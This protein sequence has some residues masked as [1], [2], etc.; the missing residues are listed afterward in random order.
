MPIDVCL[1]LPLIDRVKELNNIFAR[2]NLQELHNS[3]VLVVDNIFGYSCGTEGWALHAVN[4]ADEPHLFG[5]IREFLSPN[6]RFLEVLS[7]RLTLEFPSVYHDFPLWLLSTDSQNSV[8]SGGCKQPRTHLSL[9]AFT[10]YMFA[11]MCYASYPKWKQELALCDFENSLYRTLFDDYL[12]FYLYTDPTTV[13]V[14]ASKFHILRAGLQTPGYQKN[15]SNEFVGEYMNGSTDTCFPD[16]RLFWQTEAVLQAVCEFLLSWRATDYFNGISDLPKNTSVIPSPPLNHTEFSTKPTV[17][18]LFLVRCFLKYFYFALFN[19]TNSN[20]FQILQ[21]QIIW[22]KFL[23]YRK[24]LY[25]NQ[26][27]IVSP[28]SSIPHHNIMNR[29]SRFIVYC[30]QHWPFDLSFEVVLET[31]LSSIQPWRYSGFPQLHTGTR[32]SSIPW[33]APLNL[34]IDNENYS[35]WL[36]F[37]ARHYSL[38][39]GLLLLFME[40]VTKIDLRVS[41]NAHMVYRVTKVFSQDG[42]KM[43]LL[44]TEKI[45][46]EQ[47]QDATLSN[48]IVSE[49]QRE[50]SGLW[51][52]VIIS[53]VERVLNCMMIT[54]VNLQSE[55]IKKMDKFL[56]DSNGWFDKFTKWLCSFLIFDMDNSDESVNKCI[57]YLTEGIHSLREFFAI[58]ETFE[59]VHDISLK[60]PPNGRIQWDDLSAS[61][62]LTRPHLKS[63]PT[64]SKSP[65]VEHPYKDN[66]SPSDFS[67]SSWNID[68]CSMPKTFVNSHDSSRYYTKLT[69]LD[70]FQI[71]MGVKRPYVC[72]QLINREYASTMNASYENRYILTVCKY[73]ENKFTEMMKQHFI[74]WCSLSGIRGRFARQLLLPSS[75]PKQHESQSFLITNNPRLSFRF[76]A[77]YY[78]LLRIIFLYIFS[79]FLSG[80][81][82]PLLY[83]VCL[84]VLY[85]F[86]EFVITLFELCHE[87][88]KRI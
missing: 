72:Q 27:V 24:Y 30:F 28:E 1:S 60:P 5:S 34:K 13:N 49:Y 46:S 63:P 69:P 82:S 39:V 59:A 36:T 12:G 67:N 86:Y 2:G 85:L 50:Q 53:T 41:R 9:N 80:I 26:G 10:Y 47:Q 15:F 14:M 43:L 3:V 84:I 44:N 40:R 29:F 62:I 42:F 8:W 57:F 68:A 31:W 20:C 4:E 18:Q 65:S 35:D 32:F 74:R 45:L 48:V 66:L 11:F 73:L 61:P 22:N 58:Q 37:V 78:V 71:I 51:N 64:S 87:K 52:P 77:N 70:R 33:D 6:G 54:K 7:S 25:N 55:V 83:I 23:N 21:Q 76:L 19:N 81:S 88:V 38:Y 16:F 56:S 17:C 79:Y 75:Y